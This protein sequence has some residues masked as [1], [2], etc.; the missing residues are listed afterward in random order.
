MADFDHSGAAGA[1][2]SENDDRPSGSL[3][4]AIDP[5]QIGGNTR[6]YAQDFPALEELVVVN[7]KSI[8]EMGAYVSLLEYNGAE[9]GRAHV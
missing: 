8:A 5:N 9:I 3:S 2:D 1:S 7:V 6:F 4:T